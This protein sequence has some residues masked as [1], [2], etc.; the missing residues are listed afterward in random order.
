MFFSVQSVRHIQCSSLWVDLELALKKSYEYYLHYK[1]VIL[2]LTKTDVYLYVW[3]SKIVLILKSMQVNYV[4]KML[5][6]L[7]LYLS[8]QTSLKNENTQAETF[9]SINKC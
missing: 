4:L 2:K 7:Q 1:I 3:L 5:L 8:F 6:L 9:A